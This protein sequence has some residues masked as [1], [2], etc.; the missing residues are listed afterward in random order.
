MSDDEFSAYQ[1]KIVIGIIL[2]IIGGNVGFVLNKANTDVRADPFT[3]TQGTELE[4]RIDELESRADVF[5]FRIQYGR[6]REHEAIKDLSRRC[7][8]GCGK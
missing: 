6:S 2:A 4:R 7:D 8:M 5:D 1:R 3:G